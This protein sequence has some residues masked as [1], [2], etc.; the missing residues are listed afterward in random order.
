MKL[1]TYEQQITH[2][3]K[4]ITQPVAQA[5]GIETAQ[6]KQ[7]LASGIQQATEQIGNRLIQMEENNQAM[8]ANEQLLKFQATD[9]EKRK[10]LLSRDE[11]NAIGA[12]LDYAKWYEQESKK[13]LDNVPERLR[14]S[15]EA[16]LTDHHTQ[17]QNQV[18]THEISQQKSYL[19]KLDE[20]NVGL[21]SENVKMN[22]SDAGL[23]LARKEVKKLLD[24]QAARNGEPQEL[25]DLKLKLWDEKTITDSVNSFIESDQPESAMAILKNNAEMI[26]GKQSQD[27]MK[28]D[29]KISNIIMTKQIYSKARNIVSEFFGKPNGKSD[30]LSEVAKEYSDLSPDKQAQMR[31]KLNTEISS[32]WALQQHAVDARN[33]Q[34]LNNYNL[35]AADIKHKLA[36]NVNNPKYGQMV[37][38]ANNYLTNLVQKSAPDA[39]TMATA[40]GR[41][42]S[43][44]FPTKT[45]PMSGLTSAIHEMA[46]ND[47]LRKFDVQKQQRLLNSILIKNPNA[48]GST[49]E[50]FADPRFSLLA[51]ENPSGIEGAASMAG[52]TNTQ[53]LGMQAENPNAETLKMIDKAD[54][55]SDQT[56]A[57]YRT[58]NDWK[59][60]Y[61]NDNRMQPNSDETN[62]QAKILLTDQKVGTTTGWGSWLRKDVT[63]PAF[64]ANTTPFVK[65]KP[66]GTVIIQLPNGERVAIDPKNKKKGKR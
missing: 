37:L 56:A 53:K 52:I 60:K 3:Q 26:G 44:F 25:S 62:K 28:F 35:A 31:D 47:R 30:A 59:K 9:M 23:F 63:V 17:G 66:D 54:L 64:E 22:N 1:P 51:I 18:S 55:N 49:N 45:D 40:L 13:T 15:V 5:F 6:A 12:T 27:Y 42:Q 32:Q 2:P 38:D 57:F 50:I 39:K 14:R 36:Q 20:T 61:T 34:F 19:N 46:T 43:E 24:G 11:K 10:E 65:A 8:T 4:E 33:D 29:S 21:Q 7:Q 16:T 41:I 58:L 48:F